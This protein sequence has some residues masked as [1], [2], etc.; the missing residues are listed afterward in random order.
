M[1]NKLLL[2]ALCCFITGNIFCQLPAIVYAAKAKGTSLLAA[3]ELQRY[4]YVRTGKMPRMQVIKAGAPLPSNCIIAAT[5]NELPAQLKNTLVS[6]KLGGDAFLLR[7]I[8]NQQL[9][10]TGATD[11]SV[12]YG[13]YKFIESTGIGF[14]LQG[15]VIPDGKIGKINTTGFNKLYEPSFALRGIQPFHD[16]PEGPD[17]WR[18]E[19]YEAI[20]TQL[21]KMGMNFIGFHTYPEK[22]PFGGWEKAEPISWIGTKNDVNANGT[23]KTAY[24]VLHANTNDSTW[25]YM[26]KPTSDFNFGA[27]QI[28]ETDTYGTA[29]MQNTSQWPHTEKENIDIFNRM[30]NILQSS[31]SLANELSVKTCIGTE[32]PLTIP[33]E[34]KARLQ[35]QKK[36]VNSDAVKQE[37][38][39]GVFSRIKAM[40]KLDY[41]WFWTPENWTWEGESNGA[42]ERTEKDITN[43][44]AAAKKVNA[45]FTLATCGW[46][47]GPSRNRAEFDSIF[48]KTMPFSVINRQTGS[49]PVEPA[50]Q[51]VHG[52]PKWQISWMEDDPGLT[53]PQFWAGRTLKDA[54]DAYKY[55]CTGF[56]GI[57]WRTRNLGPSFL[58]LA[59]AGWEAASY[60]KAFP[61]DV[62]DYPA[63][64]LY[65]QWAREQFGENAA[66]QTAQIF[67]QLDGTENGKAKTPRPAEWGLKG[68][69][70]ISVNARPW[71]EVQK[72]YAYIKRFENCAS[73]V[74]GNN[75]KENYNYWLNTFYYTRA[76]AQVGCMLGEMDTTA[77]ALMKATD[78]KAKDSLVSILLRK[79]NDAVSQWGT[80]V[81]YLLQTV[82]TTGEMGTIAN[83]EQHSMQ[84][85]QSLNKHDSLLKAVTGNVPALSLPKNYTG[86]A[87]LIV[88]TR[89]TLLRKNEDLNMKVRLLANGNVQ[90]VT[91]Y[92]K[93]IN[94]TNYKSKIVKRD[95]RNVFDLRLLSNEFAN[96]DFEY[97]IEA[98]LANG[99]CLQY[100]SAKGTSQTV[101]VF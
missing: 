8:N 39:E 97:Y 71:S 4:L 46:V 90:T 69:G 32:T 58:A 48:P 15:D 13:A 51:N 26:P 81:N 88:T 47:L 79:R 63:E 77:K 14:A 50:F 52:R 74:E 83:L 33:S 76:M 56:M 38:Y 85:L 53:I 57:H 64:E 60:N 17:W 75:A 82:S 24:P 87:R 36:D 3:K 35:L 95:A 73:L 62:R 65:M 67:L 9:V 22:N 44:I 100:P 80:M 59:K 72:E 86:P 29:Y 94:T 41:Y 89:Q 30:G 92:Y 2:V 16:F 12:L 55:G 27:S 54:L 98:K 25:A 49:T 23:V 18:K 34:V 99:E 19:D 40:H 7:S 91:V 10:I 1:K 43:A 66:K 21:P 45:P 42:V 84:S 31:F 93:P 5:L 28:F 68:P 61:N 6:E 11:I 78:K 96:K 20:I 37:L 70:R 101:V